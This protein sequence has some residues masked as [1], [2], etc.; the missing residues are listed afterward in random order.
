MLQ[1]DIIDMIKTADGDFSYIGH[2]FDHHSRY[3]V[4]F[5]LKTKDA[6]HV[7]RKLCRHVFGHFGLPKILYS[8]MPRD[9]VDG[10]IHWI[11][12]LWSTDLPVINGD[13]GNKKAMPFVEQR[14]RT[15]MALIDTFRMKHPNSNEWASW[16]PCIQCE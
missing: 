15:M 2:F 9:F 4:L 10:I 16:L 3:N 7:V 5:P 6:A 14:Q 11:K 1:I 13:P 12:Q 8:T